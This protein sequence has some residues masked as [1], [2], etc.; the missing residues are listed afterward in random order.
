MVETLR[1]WSDASH[2]QFAHSTL[3]RQKERRRSTGLRARLATDKQLELQNKGIV[4]EPAGSDSIPS[5]TTAEKNEER[6]RD[7]RGGR[8]AIQWDTK[9]E[10]RGPRSAL[11]RRF[12]EC[13]RR[14]GNTRFRRGSSEGNSEQKRAQYPRR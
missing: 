8:R 4:R 2:R 12:Y 7:Q 13:G 5:S 10:S 9:P 1:T 3:R 14:V 11:F 6:A